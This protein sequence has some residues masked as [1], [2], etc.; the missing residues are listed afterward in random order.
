VYLDD[1]LIYSDNTI[2]EPDKMEMD[3]FCL[4]EG[5]THLLNILIA[6]YCDTAGSLLERVNISIKGFDGMKAGASLTGSTAVCIRALGNG[7]EQ[8]MNLERS[9]RKLLAL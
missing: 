8:L 1:K 6:G 3:G 4:Y 9:I 5:Y 2:F 7:A